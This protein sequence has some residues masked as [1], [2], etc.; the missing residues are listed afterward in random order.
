MSTLDARVEA[1]RGTFELAVDLATESGAVTAVVGPNGS[2]KSTLLRVLAGLHPLA[3]GHVRLGGRTLDD[4]A[5]GVLVPAEDRGTGLVPQE[6]LLFPHLRVRDQVAFGPRHRGSSRTQARRAADEWLQRTGLS[7]LAERKP[8]QLSGGQARRVAI[9][10][11]LAARPDLLLLDEPLAALDAGAVLTIR[12]FLHR[13]LRDVAGPTVLVTHDVLD[14]LVLADRVVVLERGRVAQQGSP[15]DVAARPRSPHVAALVGMNLVRGRADGHTVHL[16][17]AELVVAGS[18]SGE[19]Y[20][21]FRPT[22]VTVQRDEPHGSARNSW[23]GTVRGL[24]PYG[25]AVRLEVDGSLPLLADVTPAAVAEL[26][27]APGSEVWASV[28]A[29]DVDVYPA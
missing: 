23:P 16:D 25:D 10:R 8:A 14:A 27:L 11:A 19:V 21:A 29:T 13:H 12:S 20:G 24:T 6:S 5:S 2:G 4:P 15:A 1:R 18:P 7:D 9:A 26:E 3:G 22:A 28:K 17:G